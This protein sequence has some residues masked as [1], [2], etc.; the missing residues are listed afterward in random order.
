MNQEPWYKRWWPAVVAFL[1]G[2]AGAFA[3]IAVR[4]ASAKSM[5]REA[6]EQRRKALEQGLTAIENVNQARLGEVAAR[7]EQAEGE[8]AANHEANNAAIETEAR[9]GADAVAPA[10]APAALLGSL[11]SADKALKS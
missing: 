5:A 7:K 3:A 10:D 1:V 8:A 11:K 9:Q 4:I 6:Q 2:I